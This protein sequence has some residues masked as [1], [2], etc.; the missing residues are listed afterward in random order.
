MLGHSCPLLQ[1][2]QDVD[3]RDFRMGATTCIHGGLQAL[4][5]SDVGVAVLLIVADR[6][7]DGGPVGGCLVPAAGRHTLLTAASP[8]TLHIARVCHSGVQ[9]ARALDLHA[10]PR[11]R[12]S[13]LL[14]QP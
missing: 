10:L 11:S 6:P 9:P 3:L 8:H 4:L 1:R 13:L 5:L 12:Q 2:L 14:W 7:G